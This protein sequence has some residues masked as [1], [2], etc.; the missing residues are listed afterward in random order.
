MSNI[1]SGSNSFLNTAEKK[2]GKVY[3]NTGLH[4]WDTFAVTKRRKFSYS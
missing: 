1:N 3:A 4:L 2:E